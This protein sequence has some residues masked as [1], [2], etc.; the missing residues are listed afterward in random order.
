MD[1]ELQTVQYTVIM[2]SLINIHNLERYFLKTVS[3]GV[4]STRSPLRKR[5]ILNHLEVE[6]GFYL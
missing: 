6:A 4:G 2:N 5:L 3:D 1:L